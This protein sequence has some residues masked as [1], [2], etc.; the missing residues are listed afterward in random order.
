M[1]TQ[2]ADTV[3]IKL[4]AE[5]A[6]YMRDIAKAANAFDD[7]MKKTQRATGT[8]VA[9]VATSL[10]S[11]VLPVLAVQ[12]AMEVAGKAIT[13]FIENY[14]P[15]SGSPAAVVDYIAGGWNL[16]SE[17]IKGA[18]EELRKWV[19][20]MLGGGKATEAYF[21]Q[22]VDAVQAYL[23][24]VLTGWYRFFGIITD[25]L[26][27]LPAAVSEQVINIVNSMIATVEGGIN[28][29]VAAINAVSS[30]ANNIPGVNI[31]MAGNV[32]LG[33]INNQFEGAGAS[34]GKAF[35]DA[36]NRTVSVDLRKV[37]NDWRKAA[38][39]A[40]RKREGGGNSRPKGFDA[41]EISARNRIELIKQEIATLN[42]S[43]YVQTQQLSYQEMIN[44]AKQQGI[45]LTEK[46]KGTVL[47]L[48]HEYAR[49]SEELKRAEQARASFIS[50]Q[51]EA[52]SMMIDTFQGLIE[53]TKTWE[54]AL[55]GILKK[56]AD[57]AW[58]AAILGQG[59][60][61]GV[62]G[63]TSGTSA[64]GGLMAALVSGFRAN[65]GPVGR[66]NAYV[67]G[68]RGPELFVPG[69]NGSIVP[70]GALQTAPRNTSP[71][72]TVNADMRDSSST[73]IAILNGRIDRLERNLPAIIQQSTQ[74]G[75]R[76]QPYYGG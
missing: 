33:R 56:L 39:E 15:I 23:N 75:R 62:F 54:Q 8:G 9:A 24:T 55:Q 20:E 11:L 69:T 21:Q 50:L 41:M 44:R 1:A 74:N 10:K 35:T 17:A 48:S 3:T 65:G 66:G 42:E 5:V 52:G 13:E 60:L 36:M 67:V 16:V 73:A 29:V 58:Q 51:R 61:A 6:G 71:S 76:Q 68:E 14:K 63:T 26:P 38:E 53:K 27:R 46:Q 4:E 70:N 43:T 40:W 30:A 31:G 72:V 47:Q 2:T 57:M 59:P 12:T 22:A 37:G 34:A 45:T 7:G 32:D 19:V 64:P 49:A 28:R 18:L 25:A